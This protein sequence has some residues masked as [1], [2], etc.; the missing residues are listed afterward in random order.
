MNPFSVLNGLSALAVLTLGIVAFIRSLQK[1]F[2]ERK[3]LMV[4][5]G[6]LGLVV[7]CFYLG[8]VATFFSLLFTETNIPVTT[9]GLLSYTH[10]PL[11]IIDAMYLG[12]A[13]FKPNYKW[14]V[15][16]IFAMSAIPYYIALFGWTSLMFEGQEVAGEMLDIRL[17]S[18]VAIMVIGFIA[19]V[20]IIL[21]FGFYTMRNKLTG[22][23]R[24]L[25]TSLM[26][27]FFI[28]ALAGLLDT[29]L[30]SEY[31][32]I[33]RVLMAISVVYIYRGFYTNIAH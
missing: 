1:Y 24:R 18:V 20:V 27:G 14:K 29:L 7:G 6:I 22:E 5:A 21:A 19:C 2:R 16:I 13:I 17:S 12:S 28:F 11:A 10:V 30:T 3:G 9:Y 8:P 4:F 25:A 31:V 33:A 15:L 26:V 23:Q 32:A